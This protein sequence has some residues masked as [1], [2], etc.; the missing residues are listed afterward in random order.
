MDITNSFKKVSEDIL[1]WTRLRNYL[2]DSKDHLPDSKFFSSKHNTWAKLTVCLGNRARAC[3]LSRFSRV[4]LHGL[5]PARLLY[6]WDSP[7]QKTGVGCHALLQRIFLTQGFNLHLLNLLH[8]QAGSLPLAPPGKPIIYRQYSFSEQNQ[9][10]NEK[11]QYVIRF[12][13][14]Q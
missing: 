2:I 6:P 11:P 13:S 5:Q 8:W 4:W 12:Y 14:S 10:T 3:V 7:G 9:P 1:I